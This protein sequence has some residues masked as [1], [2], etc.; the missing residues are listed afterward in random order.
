MSMKNIKNSFHQQGGFTLIE[1]AIVL[2][3]IGVLVGSFLGT[4]GARIDSSR[5]AETQEALDKIKL[6]L[7][8]FAMSQSPVRLPCPDTDNDGIEDRVGANCAALTTPGNLPWATLGINRGDAWGST[9]SY[10]VADEYSNTA[11][12]DLTTD[13]TGVAQVDDSIGGNL[14]SNNVAA[15][16]ISHGKNLYGSIDLNNNARAG[17]P[18][19]TAYDDERENLDNDAAAPVL[20]ISRPVASE[21]ASTAYDDILVWLPEFELKGRMVQAGVLPP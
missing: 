5:R 6:S 4:L 9:F 16:I 13:A 20:F 12:F 17:V 3:I 2:V 8:G 1:L 15:V 7:Y 21:E 11:G 19:G 18:V 14:L 10:W